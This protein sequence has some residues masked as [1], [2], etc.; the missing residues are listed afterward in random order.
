MGGDEA[1]LNGIDDVKEK[2]MLCS[3][4]C[5]GPVCAGN[6]CLLMPFTCCYG[7]GQ[8]IC[9]ASDCFFPPPT[10]CPLPALSFS[11]A[12]CCTP[13]SAAATRWARRSPT[14]WRLAPPPPHPPSEVVFKCRGCAFDNRRHLPWL[15]ASAHLASLR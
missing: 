13:K 14:R 8:C 15:F 7:E 6:G 11:L 4:C 2:F 3:G 5:L 12:S 9:C 10:R 1:V